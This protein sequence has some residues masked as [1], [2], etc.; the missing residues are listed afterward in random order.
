[1][2]DSHYLTNVVPQDHSINGGIWSSLEKMCR[3]W[4]VRDSA[5]IIICGP[6]LTDMN[7]RTIGESNVVVPDRLFKV[8]F[9][10]YTKPPRAIGFIFP[11]KPTEDGLEALST[12]VDNIEAITGFDFFECLPDDIESEVESSTNYR[13]WNRQKR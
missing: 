7:K 1:M 2:D 13:V 3:H 8:V 12:S 6:I 5:L 11:N 10:P 4:A 9:A